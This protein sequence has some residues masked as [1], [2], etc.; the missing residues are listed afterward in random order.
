MYSF[1]RRDAPLVLAL[2]RE[3]AER[4]PRGPAPGRGTGGCGACEHV[5]VAAQHLGDPE[6]VVEANERVGNDEAALREVR[7]PSSGSGT[8]GSS[9]AT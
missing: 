5:R 2:V 6:H 7:G 9:F 4:R 3:T 8:V 1:A